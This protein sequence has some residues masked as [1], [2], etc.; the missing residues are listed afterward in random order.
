[1]ISME[2]RLYDDHTVGDFHKPPTGLFLELENTVKREKSSNY[3]LAT[4]DTRT[5]PLSTPEVETLLSSAGAS[6]TTHTPTPSRFLNSGAPVTEEQEMYAQGFLDA[7]DR[8]HH[9]Q[10]SQ[11]AGTSNVVQ[12]PNSVIHHH[13]TH[14]QAGGLTTSHYATGANPSLELAAS[15]YVTATMDYIPNIPASQSGS[16]SAYTYPISSS[17]ARDRSF[18]DSYSMMNGYNTPPQSTDHGYSAFSLGA[19]SHPSSVTGAPMNPDFLRELQVVVPNMHAQEEMKVQ[20]KKARNRIAASKCRI[21]RLQRESDLQGKVRMLK[22]HNQ[23]LNNELNSLKEQI[24][25]LKKALIQHMNKGCQVNIPEGIRIE[26]LDSV[27][28][29]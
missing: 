19:G 1:M 11:K 7:L 20:R 4:P 12:M 6:T 2:G 21:R 3:L 8:L 14:P 27:S 25:N 10:N 13:H 24:C 28:S 16:S 15:T 26:A 22:D 23:E 9:H 17:H 29:E 18:V 5:F